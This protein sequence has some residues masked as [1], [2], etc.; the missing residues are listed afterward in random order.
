MVEFFS[1]KYPFCLLRPANHGRVSAR[2]VCLAQPRLGMEADLKTFRRG[3]IQAQGGLVVVP[4][5]GR[6]LSQETIGN[7]LYHIQLDGNSSF[8]ENV[9][10]NSI[11]CVQIDGSYWK[12]DTDPMPQSIIKWAERVMCGSPAGRTH[13]SLDPDFFDSKNHSNVLKVDATSVANPVVQFTLPEHRLY[14][15]K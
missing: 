7:Y 9:L 6:T 12:L 4:L 10:F 3:I 11:R 5:T 2:W 13:K 1:L 14:E 8:F 15:E